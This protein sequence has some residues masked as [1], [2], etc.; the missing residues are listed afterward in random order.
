M[1]LFKILTRCPR[2]GVVFLGEQDSK[3]FGMALA[4]CYGCVESFEFLTPP[5]PISE[6][7]P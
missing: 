4:E 5:V 7:E 6:W 2:C 3:P 1:K